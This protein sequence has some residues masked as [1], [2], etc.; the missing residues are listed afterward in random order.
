MSPGKGNA[1]GPAI[2]L[3]KVGRVYRKRQ[4]NVKSP[5]SLFLHYRHH[6]PLISHSFTLSNN[7]LKQRT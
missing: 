2:T 3:P 7:E 5:S 4:C 1:L 6:N